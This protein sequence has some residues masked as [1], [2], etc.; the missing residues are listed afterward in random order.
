MVQ[1]T[2]RNIRGSGGPTLVDSDM[3]K[4]FLCSKQFGKA[5]V[6]LCQ[7]VADLTKILC[8]EEVH[9]DC[10]NEFV[11]CRLVPLDKGETKEGTPGVRPIGVGEVLRRLVGKLLIR[12]IKDDITTAAGPIQTCTGIKAGIE[13]AIHSMREV[14]EDDNTEAILLVDAENAFNNLNRSA[15]L[16]NIKEI[17]PPFHRYLQNTYQK[18]AK[19]V[20][21][22]E[23]NKYDIILSEEGTT[24]GDVAAMALYGLGIKPLTDRLSNV[25]DKSQ[26]KQVWYADDSTSG[27]KLVEMR[28]WWDELCISGPKYGY[29]PL[30]PKTVLI[31]KPEFEEKAKRIFGDTQVKITCEG[32]RHM[33]AVIGS[34]DFREQYVMKKVQKWIEDVNELTKI[35]KDEPQAVYSCYTKAVAHRWSYVQRTIPGIGHNFIP[36]EDTIREKLIPAIIGRKVSELER[37]ILALPIRL[38]GMGLLNPSET[39]AFEHDASLRITR[40]L[41]SIIYNQEDDFSNYD[42]ED[43][44]REIKLVKAEKEE[45]LENEYADILNNLDVKAKRVLELARENGSGAWLNALPIQSLGYTLNKQEFRDSVCLRYG[46]QIPNTPSFCQCSKQNSIDHALSCKLGGYVHMRHNRVRD[47]EAEMM[48][49][50]CQDVK[51][52][53]ELL[54]LDNEIDRSGNVAEKARLDVSGIGVWGSYERTFLDVKIVH[55]NAPSYLDKPIDKL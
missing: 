12:E 37:R 46:W 26:C 53:P 21:P 47:L 13:G 43:V 41:T 8:V 16:S 32:E 33:G 42:I 19:L 30:P 45:R 34:L 10:L 36:L 18:P 28:K 7:A 40:S 5:S 20:I 11:A 17:C 1:K 24:Q 38:G 22:G 48:A 55:P 51:I 2:A 4:H 50:V 31:V 52:E 14:Y 3:W 23:N 15:A 6:D 27:G 35:A 39:A 29:I 49:E 44:Q 9:P 25:V 54:P